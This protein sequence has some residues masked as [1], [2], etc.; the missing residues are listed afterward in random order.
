MNNKLPF[1]LLLIISTLLLTSCKKGPTVISTSVEE[2]PNSNSSSTGIFSNDG[3]LNN[4]T[5]SSP[6]VTGDVHVVKVKEVLPTDKYVYLKVIEDDE[7]FW[8][9]TGKREV[10]KGET[11][12][13]KNGILKTNFESKEYDRI[14]EKVYLVSNLVAANHG[15]SSNS[16]PSA[17]DVKNEPSKPKSERIDVEGSIRIDQIVKNPEKYKGQTVQISGTCVKL[18]PNIMGR[19]WIHLQ[20]G[21][22]DDYDFVLTSDVAIPEGHM[23]TMKGV[24]VLGKD[25]GAGYKYDLI[26]EN[27]EIVTAKQ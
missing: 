25:F 17:V 11:Y 5:S 3:E 24:V 7:E 27:A 9:A 8:I 16:L 12:F 6:P 1:L 23:V 18:N 13:F 10:Q 21:S 4:L 19:N 20:D 22:Q 15:G 26:I 14:F 2:S